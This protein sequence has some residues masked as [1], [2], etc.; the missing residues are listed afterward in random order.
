MQQGDRVSLPA[1]ASDFEQRRRRLRQRLLR[2]NTVV[3]IIL[4]AVL[5]LTLAAS[6]ASARAKHNQQR[7]EAA[8]VLAQ[9]QLWHAYLSEARAA[10]HSGRMGQRS[11]ALEAISRARAIRP[12]AELRDEAIA[13]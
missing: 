3:G 4:M 1:Q 7:A 6:V 12:S 13:A 8:E 2:I 9:E 10:R 5:V 11:S